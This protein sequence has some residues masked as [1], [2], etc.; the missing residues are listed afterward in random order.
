MFS[1]TQTKVSG[2]V[3]STEMLTKVADLLGD[4]LTASGSI[5]NA[6]LCTQEGVVVA[7]ASKREDVDPRM[8]AT[9]SAALAW[10]GR[11]TLEKVSK[12][13]PTH[14]SLVTPQYRV[15]IVIQTNYYLIAVV[16]REDDDSFDINEHLPLLKSITARIELLMTSAQEFSTANLLGNV[17]RQIPG[18]TRAMLLTLDGLP[19]GAV[20]FDDEIEVAGL[21]GSI[22]ANG[23]TFSSKT[24]YV[25]LQSE[26]NN[27]LVAR[28]DETRLLA[29]IFKDGGAPN[30]C[31]QI[32]DV[33]RQSV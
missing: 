1:L 33:I 5:K 20:G 22:F 28:V 19:L 6:V 15:F 21:V 7:A 10:V 9:V 31:E 32:V 24:D 12:S 27:L 11:T 29:V 26:E 16:N 17:V 13:T 18:V 2:F 8:L 14:V 30:I 3:L 4:V 23:L 25:V